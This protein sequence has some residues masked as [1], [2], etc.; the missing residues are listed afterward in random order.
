MHLT[1]KH[2]LNAP[3]EKVWAMLMDTEQLS[4]IVPGITRLEKTAENSFKSILE[5]KMGPVKGAFTGQLDLE[6]ISE[7]KG[8]ILKVQQNSK[9]GNAH[10][11][12]KVDLLPIEENKTE[13]SF[14]GVVRMSGMLAHMGHRVMGGVSHTLTNQFFSN[15]EKEL[16]INTTS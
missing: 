10:S 13:I 14:D 7:N 8:F 12:I 16:G 1:G 11:S 5:I 4:R 15:M 6:E 9:I 2:V 3:P